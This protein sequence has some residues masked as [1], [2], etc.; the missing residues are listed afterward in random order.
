VL[1]GT[2]HISAELFEHAHHHTPFDLVAPMPRQKAT[3]QKIRAL[4]P[5]TFTPQ[6]AGFATAALPY[7]FHHGDTC[8]FQLLQR[9]G[10][11]P[12]SYQFKAFIST[13][14]NDTVDILTADY[15]KRWHVEEFFNTHQA[16]GWKRAGTLNLHIRYSQMTLAL[17]AQAALH[18]MSQRLGPPFDSW[19]ASHLARHL[20]GGLD[21]DLR[22]RHDT[23]LVTFYN[24][25][26]TERLRQ[27]YEHL[28]EKLLE[29]NID[30]HIPWLYNFTL[31]FRFK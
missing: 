29:Q 7:R 5:E 1:A 6:W 27:H 11:R 19:E 15:P 4:P 9:G 10:E 14:H 2:E 21:G 12:D 20:L 16:L 25:P 28:P 30:P 13:R 31:D 22:V 3:Y 8:L 23:I 17:I 24:A 18:Q 26:N